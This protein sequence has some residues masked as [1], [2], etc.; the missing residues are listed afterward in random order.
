MNT[1]PK[2][3]KY[4][5]GGSL[6]FNHPTYIQRQADKELLEALKAGKFCYVFNCRQM[7]KSSL[8]VQ[9]MHQLQAEGMS[10]ASIDI[11]S[12]GSDV[13]QQQ[14]YS[15]IINQ[16]FLGFNLIGKV[17]LKAWLREREKLSSVQKLSRF[18]EDVLLVNCPG[19]KIFIFI[20]EIDKVLSL[21]F[22]LDDFFSLIR[23]CYNQRAENPEYERLTWALFGVAT[24][25]DLIKDKTQTSF[26]IGQPIELT[27]FN[28]EEVQPLEKGLKEKTDNPQAVLTRVLDWTGGQPFLTQ[29]L[30]QLVITS[31]SAIPPGKEAE[32]IG[33]LVKSRVILNWE[34]Q[35]EP[36]HLKTIRDRLLS[37]EQHVGRLLELY[38][39]ILQQ[40]EI[41]TDNSPEQS[42]LC[43]SGL[44]VKREGKLKAYN[45][46]YRSV[47]NQNWVEKELEKLRPYSEVIIAW[48]ASNYQDESRLLRGQAL[49]DAQKWAV[50][51]SLSS[52][53]YQF[54]TASQELDKRETEIN[55]EAQKQANK[56][57]TEAHQKA[58]G[59]IR[60]G[61]AILVI[62]LVGAAIA[63]GLA[64]YAFEKQGETQA[65]IQLQQEGDIAWE[66][67]KFGQIEA[68]LVAMQAGQDL[69]ALVK[70]GRLLQDYPT[71]TPLIALQQILENIR[72]TNQLEGH[73]GSVNSVSFSL[74]GQHVATASRDGTAKLWDLQG[75]E[76]VQFKGHKGAVYGVSFS[77]DGQWVATASKDGTARLWNLQGKELVQFKGHKGAVYGVSFSPDGQLLATA[78]IDDTARLWNLEG[79]ELVQFKGHKGAVYGVSFSPDEQLLATASIDGTARLWN[80][81]GKELEQFKGHQDLV[82]SVSFSPD[83]ELLA[84]ASSDGTARLWNLQGKELEQFKGH[85][86]LVNS[87]SFSPDGK[88][89]ATASSDGT[90]RLWDLQGKEIDQFKGHREPVYDVSFSPDG[91]QLAT[92]SNDSTV[93]L[94]NLKKFPM[95]GFK[96]SD[97]FTSVSFSP[98]GKLLATTSKDGVVHLWDLQGNLRNKFEGYPGWI[99]SLSFSPDGQLLATAS[100]DGTTKLWDLQ[101]NQLAKFKGDGVSVYSVSFSPDGQLL[102]TASRDGIVRL[103]NL[104]GKEMAHFNGH[105]D[106]IYGVSFSPKGQ[107]LATASRDGTARLWD[108]QGK[109]MAQFKGH[110]DSVN[111]VSFSP[112]GQL[113]ATASRDGTARLWN[114]QG[115]E[116]VEF[117]RDPFPV[118]SVSFSPDGQRVATASS[119]GTSRLWDLQGN[120]R[121]EFKGHQDSI[122]KVSF[123]ADGQRIATV[124]RDDTV[125]VWQVE[126][127]L[128]GLEQLLTKGCKW[129]QDYL[130]TH[131]KEQK[132]L[133]VCEK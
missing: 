15:G 132:K 38:Q 75:K 116:L 105:Q 113:L 114:L 119:D 101:G 79:K 34:S 3:Y 23:F 28:S 124:S 32:V 120:L 90:A 1:V 53:D 96:I 21:N 122:Y 117:K 92:A 4:K 17:N 19:E 36:V 99:D 35:D 18:I 128:E 12:I 103:W 48:E 98:D 126:E 57:L 60:I 45:P 76:L 100:R 9:T 95:A 102:A 68:L 94:W 62:S 123:S 65:G 43:L 108:L 121:A 42:E 7:G 82:N 131:P 46:I 87:I 83:G 89:L 11:T 39:Q 13:S 97:S 20:D 50:G 81:Q 80:L 115:K 71:T 2:E 127:G 59:R 63:G 26:N 8:R 51:K 33:D 6:G 78:S 85:Q 77:P 54:L 47:F 25:S 110:Q 84:T 133:E 31:C 41:A 5:V 130:A 118:N 69:K 107:L 73:E 86:D 24:P 55:L 125:R 104:K 129:L 16:L 72:E 88:L 37:N 70:D 40:G 109:E 30:C 111:S 74:D 10:C 67:F 61:Y 22:S 91:Q 93:K 27:G 14:W 58:K 112:N 52:I 56:I 106:S 49:S 29:K 44:V 66:Q 64:K